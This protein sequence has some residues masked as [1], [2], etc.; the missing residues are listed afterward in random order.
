MP[1][2]WKP[3]AGVN[4]LAAGAFAS[5]ILAQYKPGLPPVVVLLACRRTPSLPVCSATVPVLLISADILLARFTNRHC[6]EHDSR[7]LLFGGESDAPFYH[8]LFTA[9]GTFRC[10]HGLSSALMPVFHA[11][12]LRGLGEPGINIS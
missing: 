10:S 1:L 2:R 3:D 7:F 11:G 8:S 4:I 6:Q 5:A 12:T 9:T